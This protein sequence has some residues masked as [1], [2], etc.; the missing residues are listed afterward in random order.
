MS[1]AR[2]LATDSVVAVME[3]GGASCLPGLILAL[4]PTQ[5]GQGGDSVSRSTELLPASPGSA[6]GW[7]LGTKPPSGSVHHSVTWPHQ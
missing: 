3:C 7:W 4:V 5:G 1:W 6:P 2:L